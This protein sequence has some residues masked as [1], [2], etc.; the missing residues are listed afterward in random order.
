MHNRP[1]KTVKGSS[2]K[3][4]HILMLVWGSVPEGSG[5]SSS[6]AMVT[7]S[8]SAVLEICGRREGPDFIGR[9]GVTET[10]IESGERTQ[11][12]PAGIPDEAET[13]SELFVL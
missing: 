4:T 13:D 11:R 5:L 1:A 10:A 3:P 7:A 6:S 9:R 12:L 8:A 2:T